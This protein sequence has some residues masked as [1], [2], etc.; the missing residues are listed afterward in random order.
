[1]ETDIPHAASEALTADFIGVG[2]HAMFTVADRFATDEHERVLHDRW[3]ECRPAFCRATHRL[4]WDEAYA[5]RQLERMRQTG[6]QVYLTT[7]KPEA[8]RDVDGMADYAE[9][10]ADHLEHL[11]R[12]C[13]L[14][15]IRWYCVTNELSAPDVGWGGMYPESLFRFREYHRALHAAFGRRD[16]PVGLLETDASPI[17]RWDSIGWARRNM[18]EITA[19]YGGH[20]YIN[21]YIP[22]DLDFY[23]WFREE[24]ARW[25]D[26]AREPGKP[27]IVGEFG[28]K[29][30]AAPR[31]GYDLWDGCAYFNTAAEPLAAVQTAEAVIAAV[32]A[33]VH[34]IGYWTFADVPHG[35]PPPRRA[36]RWGT[37]VWDDEARFPRRQVYFVMGLLA[38]FFAGPGTVLRSPDA[39]PGVRWAT[40]RNDAGTHTAV[41]NWNRE[42]IALQPRIR[43]RLHLYEARYPEHY[44]PSA[45]LLEATD[46]GPVAPDAAVQIPPQS[47]GLITG[48]AAGGS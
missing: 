2:Y 24:V 41:V 19:A 4:D 23:R 33:G 5:V 31:Y 11:V 8:H 45:G 28:P 37:V 15:N 48:Q 16:L 47:F 39:P 34:A 35:D 43:G 7:M 26:A 27:F 17:Q 42:P 1:M 12:G 29:Q 30:H 40:L 22:G 10:V 21:A 18:S 32:N 9:R 14:T 3:A 25:V 20:H 6:T 36:N 46:R 38:R 44:R 13:G